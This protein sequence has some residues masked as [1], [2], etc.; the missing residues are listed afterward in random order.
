[1]LN[2][3][4]YINTIRQLERQI[5]E[6]NLR[7]DYRKLE[8]NPGGDATTNTVSIND[9][10]YTIT[11]Y[12]ISASCTPSKQEFNYDADIEYSNLKY[13][14]DIFKKRLEF[15]KKHRCLPDEI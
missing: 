13:K 12:T 9:G 7:L 3:N 8:L 10:A 6:Y 5:E 2:V 1:M 15:V 14:R 4:E 11:N